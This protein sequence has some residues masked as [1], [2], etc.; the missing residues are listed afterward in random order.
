MSEMI[1]KLQLNKGNRAATDL[2]LMNWWTDV[3]I[4]QPFTGGLYYFWREYKQIERRDKH[5]KR[6][7]EFFKLTTESLDTI[8]EQ[9]RGVARQELASL[10]RELETEPDVKKLFA[11]KKPDLSIL[12]SIITF[13]LYAIYIFYCELQEWAD[14]QDFEQA[15]LKQ[16]NPV[17][18]KLGLCTHNVELV[19]VSKQRNIFLA[20]LWS[21]LTFG[22][23]GLYLD[24]KIHHEPDYVFIESYKMEDELLRLI[25]RALGQNKAD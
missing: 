11:E 1:Y 2:K 10:R 12:L 15:Y 17:L 5:F 4:L 24:Y 13:G 3:F 19:K 23:Y 8:S 7:Q 16:I 20:F 14:L 21:L 25:V 9:Q 22:F 6:M 18:N